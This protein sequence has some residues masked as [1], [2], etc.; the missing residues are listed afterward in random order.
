MLTKSPGARVPAH[1]AVSHRRRFGIRL[2]AVCVLGILIGAGWLVLDRQRQ[3]TAPNRLAQP[4]AS[5]DLLTT[6]STLPSQLTPA[7]ANAVMTGQFSGVR[8]VEYGFVDSFGWGDRARTAPHGA[9]LLA[10]A[11]VAEPGEDGDS[12]PDLAV[13]VDG[14]ARGPLIPTSDYL[15]TAV[16]AHARSVD[17]VLTDSGVKQSISLLNGQPDP[18]NP[19]LSSR[20]HR[21]RE[22]NRIA[23]VRVQLQTS[24]G[25]GV[26]TGTLTVSAVSLTYWA[27]DGSPCASADQAWLH[28]VATLKLAGDARPYG[29]EAGLLSVTAPAS[30]RMVADNVAADPQQQV[31][32]AVQVPASIT[33]GTVAYS[34]SVQAAKGRITVLT[35]ITVPFVIPAG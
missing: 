34:G 15:V 1:G 12:E 32:D 25:S 31:D 16:P 29:V 5:G 9:R 4:A 24:A 35:P 10:F 2:L 23:P 22:L 13:R 19:K 17:L 27:A 6:S 21:S 14:V 20:A 3:P 30:A 7:P 28:V 11:T 8:L 18:A 26:L 33:A